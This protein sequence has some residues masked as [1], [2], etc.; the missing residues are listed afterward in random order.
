VSSG[1]RVGR[2]VLVRDVEGRLHALALGAVSAICDDGEGGALL[3]L[4]GGRLIRIAEPVLAA[5][6]WLSG[7]VPPPPHPSR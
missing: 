2:Y 6:G 4:P 3:L 1:E 5:V 7:P